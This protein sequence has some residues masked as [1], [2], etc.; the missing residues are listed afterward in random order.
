M[1]QC[2]ALGGVR[3]YAE[4]HLGVKGLGAELGVGVG[5]GQRKLVVAD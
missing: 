1:S 4:T 2:V 3:H 5:G